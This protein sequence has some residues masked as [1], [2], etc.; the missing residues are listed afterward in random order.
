MKHLKYAIATSVATWCILTIF[1]HNYHLWFT[2]PAYIFV[3]VMIIR[4]VVATNKASASNKT[5]KK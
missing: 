3:M 1:N 2:V 5:K 4:A